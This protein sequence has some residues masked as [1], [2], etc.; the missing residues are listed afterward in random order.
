MPVQ[1]RSMIKRAKEQQAKAQ[2]QVKVKVEV[3]VKVEAQDEDVCPICLDCLS[4]SEIT[5]T[6][7]GHKF[8]TNCLISSISK[9]P[10][11]REKLHSTRQNVTYAEIIARTEEI[12][13]QTRQRIAQTEEI[14]RQTRQRIEQN[15]EIARQ[16]RQRIEQTEEIVRQT[17]QRVEETRQQ[18][19]E[20]HNETQHPFL[21]IRNY[22]GRIFNR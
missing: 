18:I 5:T 14:E 21:R 22:L 2:T 6:K 13:R 8:H 19:N 4:C 3:Q 12:T 9:C 11:C 17:R 20:I 1:T 7:C 15:E 10:M 16:I